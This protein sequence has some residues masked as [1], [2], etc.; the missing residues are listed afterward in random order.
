[1]VYIIMINKIKLYSQVIVIIACFFLSKASLA[2]FSDKVLVIIDEDVITQSEFNYRLQAVE[3]EIKQSG[4]A[5]PPGFKKQLLDNMVG[6]RLQIQEAK[7]RGINIGDQELDLAIQRFAQQQNIS[8]P[9]LVRNLA[10]SGQSVERFRET[11]RD[12]LTISR[13][14]EFYTR[15]R[16]VVPDYEIDGFIV[17]N[18]MEDGETEYEI[19]H[20]LIKEPEVNAELAQKVRDEIVEGLSFQ[21]AVLRYSESTDAQDGG[22]MGWRTPAQ[23]PEIYVNAIK[24]L[25]VGGITDVIQSPNGLHILKLLN[26]KG[27]RTEIVQSKVRHILIGSESRVAKSQAAKKL[28]NLRQRIINGEDFSQLARIFSDDSVSAATGGS[29]DWVSPGQMVKPFEETY[30]QLAIGEISQPIETQYGVHII[31]VNDRRKK[32]VTDQVI[33]GKADNFLRRQR[34]DREFNQWV[35]ELK[36]QAYVEYLSEPA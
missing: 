3:Q 34:A 11:V 10:Q 1:M 24:D 14:T 28:S 7:R 25:Q 22:L 13:L 17:A 20:I 6:D 26:M 5:A 12:S 33:R 30:K 32:N 8:V 21:E 4:K 23:L 19:A 36:E 2:D 16:V 15:T 31:Q 29:L 27:D 35:R 18:N 9:D